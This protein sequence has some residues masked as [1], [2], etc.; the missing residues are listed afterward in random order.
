MQRS[1]AALAMQKAR[2]AAL[3]RRNYW[4]RVKDSRATR[5]I[6]K[7]SRTI[8][9][10]R[11]TYALGA[12]SQLFKLAS[13][14]LGPSVAAFLGE[15]CRLPLQKFAA[16]EP[17][18]AFGDRPRAEAI[19]A[20]LSSLSFSEDLA[21]LLTPFLVD[22]IVR[23]A[24][25][26]KHRHRAAP[27][28]P[29]ASVCSTLS[30]LARFAAAP[31]SPPTSPVQKRPPS[32]KPPARPPPP[33]KTPTERRVYFPDDQSADAD[34]LTA[35]DSLTVDEI[36]VASVAETLNTEDASDDEELDEDACVATAQTLD[37]LGYAVARSRA[38]HPP[39][40]RAS[41]RRLFSVAFRCP[42]PGVR[43]SAAAC[44]CAFLRRP[45]CLMD[46]VDAM[47][48]RRRHHDEPRPAPAV[49]Q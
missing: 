30:P 42:D 21:C 12:A 35:A 4:E 24:P 27:L 19:A 15:F 28:S 1:A 9:G 20:A 40:L 32:A 8:K 29:D 16:L 7:A 36:T 11:D 49:S 25:M 14:E 10:M 23:T 48:T 17:C 5:A 22:T 39:F 41:N 44:A 46:A 33:N 34:S 6:Q 45:F 13:E 2:R 3:D 18:G 37:A 38:C 47:P 43:R 31:K 26:P